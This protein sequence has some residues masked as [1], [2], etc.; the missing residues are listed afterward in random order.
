MTRRFLVVACAGTALS[1]AACGASGKDTGDRSATR[2]ARHVA[3]TPQAGKRPV[4]LFV[5]TSL[6]A[7][8]GLQLEEAYPALIEQLSADAGI[9]V[10]S[11][12]AGV[13]GETSAGALQRIGW[14]LRRPADIVV[15]ETGA[16][17]GLRAL[18]VLGT[19]F[20]LEEIVDSVHKA[21]PGV[22][23]LLVQM[24]APRNLGAGYYEP[25]HA[26]YG[27]VAR[28]KGAGVIPFL[29][30]SVAE[31]P[32]LNQRDGLHPNAE[33][34]VIVARNVWRGLEPTIRAWYAKSH[35]PG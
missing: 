33:G 17:D 21:K 22:P 32:T 35:P 3:N 4:V 20:N 28:E 30:D 13:S 24:E 25:F 9:P 14:V 2:D 23:V 34:E 6:T 11:I 15:I 7:G 1:A 10:T 31:N 16:N 27:E 26:M 12:N 8:L 18:Q 29:L 19:K 5:G